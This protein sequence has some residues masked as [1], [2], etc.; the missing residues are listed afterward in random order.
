[1]R[2][3]TLVDQYVSKTSQQYWKLHIKATNIPSQVGIN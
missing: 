1:M 2:R 3:P